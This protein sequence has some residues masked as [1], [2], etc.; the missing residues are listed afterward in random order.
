MQHKYCF[1]EYFNIIHQWGATPLEDNL[2][3]DN[4]HYQMTVQTGVRKNASTTS[5][6]SFIVSG[7]NGDSGV[8]RLYDGHRKVFLKCQDN[9]KVNKEGPVPFNTSLDFLS[10]IFIRHYVQSAINVFMVK[11]TLQK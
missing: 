4:Y 2:P 3:S 7:E 11:V 1:I 10:E 9:F 8:R 5:K 6:V